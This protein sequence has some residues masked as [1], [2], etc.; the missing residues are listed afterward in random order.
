MIEVSELPETYNSYGDLSNKKEQQEKT[1]FVSA[2]LWKKSS[3]NT[4]LPSEFTNFD[5]K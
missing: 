4:V 5:S 3:E 1:G 2:V